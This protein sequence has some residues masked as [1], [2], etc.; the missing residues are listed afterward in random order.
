MMMTE[1]LQKAMNDQIKAE[2]WSSNL[3]LSMSIYFEKEGYEGFASW[4]RAQAKEEMEHAYDFIGY[5]QKRG[6][7]PVVSQID[8]VPTEWANP[9]A[10]FEAV[11]KHETYVSSLIDALHDLCVE[12]KDKAS[13]DFLWQY[14]REQVEEEAT[15]GAIVEKAKKAGETGLL[16]LDLKLAERK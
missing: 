7:V 15:T 5:M 6:A 8:A 1:K 12:E 14:I 2:M 13:Q 16:M 4:M 10:V 9:L 11:Y 3:Y